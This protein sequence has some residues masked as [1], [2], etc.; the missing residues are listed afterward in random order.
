MLFVVNIGFGQKIPEKIKAEKERIEAEKFWNEMIEAK[1]GREKL[2][3]VS[4]MLI[5]NDGKPDNLW[6]KFWVYPYKYWNWDRDSSYYNV[7]R[8]IMS[9]LELRWYINR[10]RYEN[11]DLGDEAYLSDR[12]SYQIT[13]CTFLLET[14]WFQPTPI[15]VTRQKL[16][17]TTIDAIETRFPNL[18]YY[19]NWGLMYYVDTETLLPKGVAIILRDKVAKPTLFKDYETVNGIQMPTSVENPFGG[20]YFNPKRQGFR[21]VKIRLNVDHNKELF[22]KEP[23]FESG[24][25]AWK[26][27]QNN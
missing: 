9:N 8:V 1:G 14:K 24:S 21:S 6:I 19:K 12:E 4:N 18:E 22:E 27:K 2:H 5:T 23:T 13:A 20:E 11:K 15:R 16:G 25:N 26:P 7:K 10:G 17:R 3:S